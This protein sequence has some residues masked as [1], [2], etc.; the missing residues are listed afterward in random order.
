MHENN[1]QNNEA[2]IKSYSSSVWT[3]HKGENELKREKEEADFRFAAWV[4]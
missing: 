1:E 2:N 4:K 3:K